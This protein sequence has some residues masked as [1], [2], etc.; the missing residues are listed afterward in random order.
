MRK[1]KPTQVEIDNTANWGTWSKEISTFPWQ[2]DDMETCFILE[3][4]AT[5][6]DQMGNSLTFE[7]GDM[8]QFEQGM[9]CTWEITSDIRKKFMF[10]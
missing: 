3:G 6:K 10:G 1:W 4:K 2:Y 9:E 7:K 5:V 8:V